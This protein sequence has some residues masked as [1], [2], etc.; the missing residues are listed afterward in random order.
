MRHLIAAAALL[1][2]SVAVTDAIAQE[3]DPPVPAE[4]AAPVA[5]PAPAKPIP[6]MKFSQEQTIIQPSEIR[7]G[8]GIACRMDD[9]AL[10]CSIARPAPKAAE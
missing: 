10:V 8:P 1:A 9:T 7:I 2:F 5:V 3:G 4:P 6:T